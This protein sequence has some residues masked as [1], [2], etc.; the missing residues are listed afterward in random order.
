MD[1]VRQLLVEIHDHRVLP[2]RL[3]AGGVVAASLQPLAAVALELDDLGSAP[4]VL[5]QE[6]VGAGD[7][8]RRLQVGAPDEDVRR[9]VE[10]LRRRRRRR[11]RRAPCQAADRLVFEEQPFDPLRR[12][13][14]ARSRTCFDQVPNNDT[15]NGFSRSMNSSSGSSR[16]IAVT[17]LFGGAVGEP[18]RSSSRP[19]PPARCR[20]CRRAGRRR[21]SSSTRRR[22]TAASALTVAS[23]SRSMN[24]VARRLRDVGDRASCAV[25]IVQ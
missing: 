13:P 19:R 2:A 7:L 5:R 18:G 6:G 1:A 23:D 14:A 3:V 17:H 9:V 24:E 10:R 22:R 8:L 21:R 25:S 4:G 15:I 11:P 20:T 12:D 16:T